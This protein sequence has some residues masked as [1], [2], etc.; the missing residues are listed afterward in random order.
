MMIQLEKSTNESSELK[1]QLDES[2][3]DH[4]EHK[5]SARQVDK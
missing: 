2:T 4:S 5:V 3:K 1:I